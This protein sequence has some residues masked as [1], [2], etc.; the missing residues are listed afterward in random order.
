MRILA[1]AAIALAAATAPTLAQTST[2]GAK[3]Q[4]ECEVDW[5]AADKNADGQ[6]DS[7]EHEAA[8]PMMPTSLATSADVKQADFMTACT[9]ASTTTQ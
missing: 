3:S 7:T 6:L 9:T 5:K 4:A 1:I 8:K 2:A